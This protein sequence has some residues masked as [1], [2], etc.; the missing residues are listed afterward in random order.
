[1]ATEQVRAMPAQVKERWL[2]VLPASRLIEPDEVAA[3]V[4]FLAS[5]RR[6]PSPARRS[7]STAACT[8]ARCRWVATAGA[9]RILLPDRGSLGLH[10]VIPTVATQVVTMYPAEKRHLIA[11]LPVRLR[12]R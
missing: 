7:G 5:R 6:P 3:R 8:S 11:A 12:S 2:A 10:R 1:V 4:A 9:P